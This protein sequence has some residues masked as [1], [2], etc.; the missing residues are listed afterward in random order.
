MQHRPATY[1]DAV[2]KSRYGR[3]TWIVY[4][5]KL[6]KQIIGRW[7]TDHVRSALLAGGTK[8]RFTL[9]MH[10]IP[11]LMNW[12]MGLIMLRNARVGVTP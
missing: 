12:R 3:K 7:S 1:Q 9:I 6:G 2:T 8:V 5:D 11:H 10:G 4:R